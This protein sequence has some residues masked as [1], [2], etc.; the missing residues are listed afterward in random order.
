M[1]TLFV[2]QLTVIDASY[3]CPR[4]GLVGESWIVDLELEGSLDEQSM[5]LDFGA[6]KKQ[7]KRAIDAYT[8]SHPMGEWMRAIKGI[9]PIISGGILAHVDIEKALLLLVPLRGLGR[10]YSMIGLL[11]LNRLL[12]SAAHQR[13]LAEDYRIDG[14]WFQE[15][16]GE[17]D[18]LRSRFIAVLGHQKLNLNRLLKL[19]CE[20][21]GFSER[22]K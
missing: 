19:T 20:L 7:L 9:G 6:V 14:L 12:D 21:L 13:V 18:V 17:V 10:A 15:R 8:K 11:K 2:E 5:V 22:V 16:T 1:T 4:R 3:L